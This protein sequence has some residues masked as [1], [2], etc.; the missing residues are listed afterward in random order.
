MIAINQLTKYPIPQ[1]M[2]KTLE[3]A[4]ERAMG[5]KLYNTELQSLSLFRAFLD[6][7]GATLHYLQLNQSQVTLMRQVFGFIYAEC[8]LT[9]RGVK[10]LLNSLKN[11]MRRVFI[12]YGIEPPSFPYFS[13]SKVSDDITKCVEEYRQL[14]VNPERLSYYEGWAVVCKGGERIFVDLSCFY[15]K[16]GGEVTSKLFE[17]ACRFF[18]TK[19]RET[20]QSDVSALNF[21]LRNIILLCPTLEHFKTAGSSVCVDEF[22]LQLFMVQKVNAKANGHSIKSFYINTWPRQLLMVEELLIKSRIWSQRSLPLF[23]PKYKS[24]STHSNTHKRKDEFGNAFNVKLV[25]HIPL[26]YTD[27]NAIKALLKSIESDIEFVSS[28]FRSEADAIMDGLA[29]RKRLAAQGDVINVKLRNSRWYPV[30]KNDLAIDMSIPANVCAN[31]E[32]YKWDYPGDN[33]NSFLGH[34]T[35]KFIRDFGL[36]SAYVLTPFLYLLIKEHPSITPSW[37]TSFELYDKNDKRKGFVQSGQVWMAISLKR[38][39]GEKLA[40]QIITLNST[41]VKLLENIIELTAD[42]RKWMKSQGDNDWRF[43]LLSCGI[44]LSKPKR[45]KTIHSFK[46]PTVLASPVGQ[47]LLRP[48]GSVGEVRAKVICSNLTVSTFRASCGVLVYLKTR[49]V[50]AMS[51]ALGHD[52]CAPKL[53]SSYLP[54]PILRYFQGRWVRV[55]QNALVYEAMKDSNKLFEAMDITEEE[56]DEF[57]R[58]HGLKPLPEHIITGQISDLIGEGKSTTN[59]LSKDAAI[60]V[61]I[62]LLRVIN[63]VVEL[64]EC[65]PKQQSFTPF[66]AQWYE[67]SKFVRECIAIKQCPEEIVTAMT[68]AEL[69]P[70]PTDKMKGAVYAT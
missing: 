46:S 54:D 63:A 24:S 39:K 2:D 65:A 33:V 47:A 18:V 20:A 29:N 59:K 16:F 6:I 68:E 37:L 1:V 21:V 42:A 32:Q 70:L 38:R 19:H 50:K 30:T 44:G 8:G 4:F 57:L 22:I 35:T 66:T 9:L 55:F 48:N 15:L 10:R 17:C 56:L 67:T 28:V 40:Q 45:I 36:L 52:K 7:S 13:G 23:K 27:D 69:T 61:S 12:E 62:P 53:L 11:L 34:D 5:L 49:S 58:N 51:E 25:T 26:S 14:E 64:V 31:W 43:L 60:P 41:S 3:D